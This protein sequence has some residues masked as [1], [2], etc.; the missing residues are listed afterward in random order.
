MSQELRNKLFEQYSNR[1]DSLDNSFF[2]KYKWFELYYSKFYKSHI[3]SLSIINPKILEIGCNRGYLLKVLNDEGYQNLVGI[4]LSDDDLTQAKKINPNCHLHNVDA[5]DF[6]EN[7][8]SSFDVIIIKAVL[9]HIPKNS[10]ENLLFL[11]KGA[12][13]DNGIIIIDVPN[14]DWFFASHER[15]MDFTHEV[16]FTKESMTQIVSLYFN[17]Y[18]IFTADNIFVDHWYSK[19]KKNIARWFLN[20]LFC[21]A[22]GQGSSNPI[23]DRSLIAICQN[24]NNK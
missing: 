9:E 12:L 20:L 16:G 8:K 5:F 10:I 13:N 18:S 4:D 19:I 23:W 14:M 6:L 15:Y 2:E 7:N 21:W 11:M 24:N 22:D 3:N 1:T 17:K